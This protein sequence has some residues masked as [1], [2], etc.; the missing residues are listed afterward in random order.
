MIA[1][2]EGR[3]AQISPVLDERIEQERELEQQYLISVLNIIELMRSS[4]KRPVFMQNKV[5]MRESRVKR[6]GVHGSSNNLNNLNYNV[7]NSVSK[8]F[9]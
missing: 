4:W 2:K 9:F 8:L 5:E 6:S 7:L 3:I 1:E